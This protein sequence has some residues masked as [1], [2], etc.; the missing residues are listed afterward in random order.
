[1]LARR[2]DG[3]VTRLDD[4]DWTVRREAL[5]ILSTLKPPM[6][7]QHAGAVAARLEDDVT[8]VRCA[9]LVT[10]RELCLLY[11]SPSPRDRG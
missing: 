11:T 2:A 5:V 10:L 1:M 6:L 3:V 9:A 4:D 8:D 7:A